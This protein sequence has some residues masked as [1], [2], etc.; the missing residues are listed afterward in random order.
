MQTLVK[1]SYSTNYHL[2]TV[3]PEPA[4]G[5]ISVAADGKLKLFVNAKSQPIADLQASSFE[6]MYNSK[7]HIPE[8]HF[9]GSDGEQAPSPNSVEWMGKLFNVAM[10]LGALELFVLVEDYRLKKMEASGTTERNFQA[11][12]RI[13][14][15][16]ILNKVIGCKTT[17]KALVLNT[18]AVAG[19]DAVKR[20]EIYDYLVS[21][22]QLSKPIAIVL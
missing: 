15:K 14:V 11:Y 9:G 5:V 19:D 18:E 20:K 2:L 3:V 10:I 8:I 22:V 7:I 21:E 13:N 16:K 1:G 4:H 17:G 12:A 6:L